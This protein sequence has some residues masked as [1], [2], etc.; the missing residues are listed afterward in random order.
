MTEIKPHGSHFG[1]FE[2]VVEGGR[3]VEARPF[4]RDPFPG[5][6]LQSIPDAVH[7]AARIDRPY[8][9][10]GWL[11]GER[12]GSARGGDAFVP[13]SWDRAIRLVAEE[14]TRIRGEHGHA[15]VLGGSYGWSSAGRYHHA[16]TQ[17]HRFLGLAGGFTAQVTNYSYGAG[18][19]LMP[20]ILG[21]NEVIQGPV[22]D[23]AA[24]RANARVM[25][26]FGGL[27]L[28]NGLI[29]SGG[30]GAHE[31]VPLMKAAAEAGLRFVNISP[32]RGDVAEF[33]GAEWVPIRPGSDAAMILAMAQV[34]LEAGRQD[35]DFLAR[36]AVGFAP[37]AAYLRG[38]TDGV[39]KT[40][41]W[42][43]KL[44]DVPA[45]TIRRLALEIAAT[46]NMLTATWSIQR[47]E[48]GE[49]P[50][51]ALVALAATLGTI[52][53]AGQGV[54]FGYGSMNGIGTP[55][56]EV[57]SVAGVS[58]KNPVG[59]YIPV[60]RVTEL[61]ER[62]GEIL[63]YN[64][65]D[66][67]LPDIRMIWWG[68]GNPFHHHQDLGRLLRGWNRAD[69]VVVQE[70]WWTALARH[71]DIVLPAT[72]SLERNDI[73]SASRDR[74]VRAMHQAIAPVGQARNDV[75]MLADIA[76]ALGFRAAF[77]EQRDEMAWL[78]HLYGRWRQA[79]A[80]QGIEVPDFAQFWEQGFV[81]IPPPA[82]SY[83]QFAEFRS[84][85][86]AHPLNTATGKVEIFCETIARFGYAEVPGHPVWQE[87][88]EW[89][90]GSLAQRFPLHMLSFQPFTRLHGQLDV[91]RVAAANRVQG[92]EPIL[93]HPDDAAARGLADGEVVRVFNDRGA[94]A[95][96]LRVTEAIRPGVVAMATGAWWNPARPGATDS[97]C[98]H[99]N[100]NVLTQD[101]GTS[102]LGQGSAAQSCLV[103]IARW[104]GELTPI[105]V[106]APPEG[107]T[108]P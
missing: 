22:T 2:A 26:C 14:S 18:M 73:G 16:R 92:R 3:L 95:A 48:H 90:G 106:H 74:F 66:L 9:R 83:T 7:S 100:A 96:G 68:G 78:D 101:V 54:A 20:H 98:L 99:G 79:C 45:E 105:R 81:E 91:G 30:S 57:P 17:L 21:T 56:H 5:S 51:W 97:P 11:K 88:R 24:I 62:P 40:P 93:M 85:P 4:A 41:E 49:Q 108:A 32:F 42:A 19:T 94:I 65:R 1:A 84:D 12:R 28:K 86:E 102:R 76:D 6:L 13:V 59:A 36:C 43:T 61:L 70:P 89:L 8:V 87:P 47:A 82:T 50:W 72:T 23:W 71:A 52:G 37:F 77:T 69:T 67:R 75:D 103:E 55:R 35:D 10:A 15:S 63:Q 44:T 58:V 25:L 46:P 38:E 64:G 31:Y 27:P 29:T 33:L 104:E 34:I 80:A 53:K 39:A 60:A 107:A